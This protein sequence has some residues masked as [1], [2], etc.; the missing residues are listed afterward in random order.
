MKKRRTKTNKKI[1][2]TRES[3]RQIRKKKHLYRNYIFAREPQTYNC[4]KEVEAHVK[5]LIKDTVQRFEQKLG[6]NIKHD[7]ESFYKYVKSKQQ[8]KDSIGPQKGQNG[9]ISSDSKFTAEELNAFFAL[10]FTREN[11]DNITS[12][13]VKFKGDSK[14]TLT[15]IKD[16]CY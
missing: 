1:W 14:E 15:D 7:S 9:E 4:Y 11:T 8:I 16:I 10:S 12:S 5:Q 3:V 13:N 2:I 6:D